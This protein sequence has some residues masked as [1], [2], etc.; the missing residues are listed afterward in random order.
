MRARFALLVSGTSVRLREVVLRDKPPQLVEISAKATVPVLQLANGSVIDESLEIMDW[1]L[2]RH[3]PEDWRSRRD[4]RLIAESDGPFK[5]ALDRYKYPG[6]FEGGDWQSARDAGLTFLRQLNER[7]ASSRFLSGASVGLTDVAIFPFVRQFAATDSDW[8]A[9][10]PL[11]LLH[12]WLARLVE[13]KSFA[14][15]MHRY[16]RWCPEDD[17]VTFPI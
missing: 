10:Q 2:A 15:V 7:L 17:P 4:D 6:R 12:E 8:F 1:A 11:A 13:S 3:D 14:I 5:E 9:A 16:Q